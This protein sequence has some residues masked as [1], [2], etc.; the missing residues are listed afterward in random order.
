MSVPDPRGVPLSNQNPEAL[1]AYET[2]LGRFQSYVGDPV[3][4]LD[5]ALEAS[6]EFVLGHLFRAFTLRLRVP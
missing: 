1:A 5:A 4:V 6:P 3:E 2:A